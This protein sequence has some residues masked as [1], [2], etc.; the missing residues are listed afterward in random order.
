[1]KIAKIIISY[2]LTVAMTISIVSV[3]IFANP[4]SPVNS[5]IKL[6]SKPS[7]TGYTVSVE[8]TS[9]N[10]SQ[11][12]ENG[13]HAIEGFTIDITNMMTNEKETPEDV[14]AEAGDT[15]GKQYAQP[16]TKIFEPN[17]GYLYKY[18][19]TPYHHHTVVDDSTDPPTTTTVLAP[20]DTAKM[21]NN[22]AFFL[23]DIKVD[24]TG[25]GHSI[26]VNWDNPSDLITKYKI[27]YQKIT[28]DTDK[29]TEGS[30][31]IDITDPNLET[32]TDKDKGNMRYSYTITDENVISS[33]NMYDIILEPIFNG[34]TAEEGK[35]NLTLIEDGKKIPTTVKSNGENT[36]KYTTVVTTELPMDYEEID[37][38]Q[39]KLIWEG[40]D[41]AT[42]DA[43]DKFELQ[44]STD[45]TFKNYSVIMTYRGNGANIGNYPEDKPTVTT[46]YRA[47]VTF[48]N[49]EDGKV[50]PPMYS[51]I[52][53]YNPTSI[54]FKPN[55][56]DIL[57]V[58][59]VIDGNSYQLDMTWSAFLRSPYTDDERNDSLDGEGKTYLDKDVKYDIWV[60]DDMAG[61]YDNRVLPV[62]QDLSPDTLNNL[63][64]VTADK[65]TVK[66][67]STLINE[68]YK[69][70]G[71]GYEKASLVPNTLY[72]IKIVAKKTFSVKGED[73]EY[74]SEPEYI[75]VFFNEAGN[76]FTPPM[77]SK[78]PLKIKKDKDGKDMIGKTDVTIEWK[79]QWWEIF[80]PNATT[81]DGKGDWETKFKVEGGKLVFGFEG[82][83]ISVLTEDDMKNKVLSQV[84]DS[85]SVIYRPVIF[86]KDIKYEYMVV[87][88]K[89]IEKFAKDN[90]Q[91]AD[92]EAKE[93]IY[94]DY[95]KNNILSKET[96]SD[97]LFTEI[98][99]PTVDINDSQENTLYTTIS[100]LEPNTEYV[101]LFR[102]YRQLKDETRLKSSPA[103]LTVTTLPNDTELIE[104]PTVPTLLLKEKDD[105]SITVKWKDDGFKYELVIDERA[106]EDPG[107][108]T[109]ISSDEI[110]K[111]CQRIKDDTEIGKDAIYYKINGLFP[112]T[113]YYIWVRAISDTAPKPS[114][115][116]SPLQ[117]TT[118]PL[119]KP[120]PPMGL[121]LAS[122]DSLKYINLADGSKYDSPST[123]E[124]LI[125][126][127]MKD[128]ND[129]SE[130]NT[131]AMTGDAG[132]LGAPEIK[133]T[134]VA[135]YKNLV[136][137]RWY[138][139]RVAT[140]VVV[141]KGGEN[142][143]EK[144]FSYVIELADN[145]DFVDA[146]QIEIPE[147]F[148]TEDS[149][150]YKTEISDF[151]TPKKFLTSRS[152]GEY[153]SDVDPD[154][155]PLPDEDF[156]LIYDKSTDTLTHR[157]RSNEKGEDGMPD[158]R[159]DQRVITKLV[160]KGLYT[161]SI[162]VSTYE[163]KLVANRIVEV[164]YTLVKAFE[165][166][167]IAI[168]IKA[169]NLTLTLKPDWLNEN[170]AKPALNYGDGSKLRI[171]LNQGVSMPLVSEVYTNSMQYISDAQKLTLQLQTPSTS[172][173]IDYTATP[174]NV[175]LKLDNQYD[176][177]DKNIDSYTYNPVSAQW[178]RT[179]GYFEN[180]NARLIFDTNR[181]SAYAAFA[182]DAPYSDNSSQ[183]LK[184]LSNKI[185]ITDM[186][187]YSATDPITANQL[188][189]L[190]YSV[191][192]NQKDVEAN[193][194]LSDAERAELAKANLNITKTG[195]DSVSRQEAI[196]SIVHL[197]ELKTGSRINQGDITESSIED[198]DAVSATY[199]N[200]I[201][202][203][204]QIG[205][206][207]RAAR[208]N[209][210]IT[211]D[212]AASMLNMVLEDTM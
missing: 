66:A 182:I 29:S 140:R 69:K 124:Y 147:K 126:E 74:I 210:S 117:V 139:V 36:G 136:A 181:V 79:K 11:D 178:E 150:T 152:S 70:T 20:M 146:I 106:L 186:K 113:Q 177:Y 166:R 137:N 8:W 59:P 33:A 107:T 27:S 179:T 115:W 142:G 169:D 64:F 176:I 22:I 135:M 125:F 208:P 119:A 72:Y 151:C 132:M 133:S 91:N 143:I 118:D 99:D 131:T 108:G 24:G 96:A 77:M 93:K 41:T 63:D 111:N 13:N 207:D 78:P 61:L 44:K 134:M 190:I 97:S 121:G 60:T 34:V 154:L 202:K 188:G 104:I 187:D 85:N 105:I 193:K 7:D 84:S 144:K 10:I 173:N 86:D 65:N 90:Y 162:D 53:I 206:V 116:S 30:A 123:A 157:L 47:V 171:I 153:D 156:E 102:S 3:D 100:G 31:T 164:P 19:V 163:N 88:Y 39:I 48:K 92:S 196:N 73:K 87:P 43:I 51:T 175:K 103:Y 5:G 205:M 141:Q 9:P 203:A 6:V 14:P 129:L 82:D 2:I 37:E 38:K 155:Y 109:I 55:K 71:D 89:D 45:D 145:E 81:N 212:E 35:D 28:S 17:I 16:V 58:K 18:A 26:T 184:E 138:W 192:K 204:E 40:L 130:G 52:V 127:W 180:Q 1:M 191:A 189:N 62:L 50:R 185:N 198:M 101:I 170:Q 168:Q 56:P 165:E 112:E 128:V 194:T 148:E 158:N 197:Y 25:A 95:V 149:A 67:Y 114:A 199:Q 195:N 32:F 46:Y 167:K 12:S 76:L 183:S 160:N 122:M 94:D 110:E 54:P 57:Q 120:D 23:T 42:I 174:M 172:V 21:G 211:V 83:G 200:G 80:N 201:L 98:T 49:S 161:Y 4:Q 68:C 159:V 209:D 15:G 75:L